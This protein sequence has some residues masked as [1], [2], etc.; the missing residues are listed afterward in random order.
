MW[1]MSGGRLHIRS[2]C[3]SGEIFTVMDQAAPGL[4]AP[5]GGGRPCA[6]S[7]VSAVCGA[8]PGTTTMG[9]GEAGAV[10]GAVTGRHVDGDV[11][12]PPVQLGGG[13]PGGGAARDLAEQSSVSRRI[14]ESGAPAVLCQFPPA[15]LGVLCP[16]SAAAPALI[17]AGHLPPPAVRSLLRRRWGRAAITTGQDRSRSRAVRTTVEP[18]RTVAPRR[19][20]SRTEMITRAR[21]DQGWHS[22]LPITGCDGQSVRTPTRAAQGGKPAVRSRSEPSKCPVWRTIAPTSDVRYYG[23]TSEK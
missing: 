10:R 18:A 14:D 23:H 12:N 22:P 9:I 7:Q 8:A 3:F 16:A 2:D 6:L 4:S 1:H 20:V 21:C 5:S 17:D 11:P 19:S 13:R 15:G